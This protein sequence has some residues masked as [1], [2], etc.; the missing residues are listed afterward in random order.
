MLKGFTSIKGKLPRKFR[1][2]QS[3]NPLKY[4]G[5]HTVEWIRTRKLAMERASFRCEECGKSGRLEAHHIIPRREGGALYAATNIKVLCRECHLNKH[6]R[7]LSPTEEK[8]KEIINTIMEVTH[9]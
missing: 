6:K 3:K 4:K 2:N 1:R 9:D 8:W 5:L 7:Q